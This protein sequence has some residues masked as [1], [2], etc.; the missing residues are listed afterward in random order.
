MKYKAPKW[1]DALS[2]K[3]IT[4]AECRYGALAA[5]FQALAGMIEQADL[6][7]KDPDS[8]PNDNVSDIKHDGRL[9]G[10][11]GLSLKKG[12][13]VMQQSRQTVEMVM[14]VL[15]SVVKLKL[16]I[17]RFARS[18]DEA[19]EFYENIK[20]NLRFYRKS[21]ED[22]CTSGDYTLGSNT[23]SPPC[24]WAYMGKNRKDGPTT[25]ELI[26]QVK[27]WQWQ[28]TEIAKAET[29]RQI[30]T[31]PKDL[32]TRAVA[33]RTF[34]VSSA[35]LQRK[36]KNGLITKHKAPNAGKTTPNLWSKAELEKVFQ[37]RR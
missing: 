32:I 21:E 18:K 1:K 16:Q 15:Y 7:F 20:I 28:E 4:E 25:R 37:R 35:T 14:P 34:N 11:D 31:I 13:M 8:L 26:D 33:V 36:A 29:N 17:E 12:D 22:R 5:T 9:A 23:I 10:W 24:K 19:K 30:P 3:Q 27:H 6:V 2:Q